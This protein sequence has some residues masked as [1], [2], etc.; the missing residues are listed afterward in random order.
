[1]IHRIL[2]VVEL[3]SCGL[4][5]CLLPKYLKANRQTQ[6]PVL[7][8]GF[9]VRAGQPLAAAGMMCAIS[10]HSTAI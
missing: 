9:F 7:I 4:V 8:P 3:M 10:K 1:V 5:K 2:I 6:S